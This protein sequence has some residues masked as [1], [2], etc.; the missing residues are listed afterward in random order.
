[1]LPENQHLRAKIQSQQLII[2]RLDARLTTLEAVIFHLGPSQADENF[3]TVDAVK[4][5]LAKADIESMTPHVV[6]FI[7]DR[8]T[9]DWRDLIKRHG[10]VKVFYAIRAQRSIVEARRELA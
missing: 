10:H 5:F 1:M 6:R 4:D 3:E 2:D 8:L 9:V 7:G